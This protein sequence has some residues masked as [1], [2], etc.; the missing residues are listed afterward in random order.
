MNN[1]IVILV[2][3]IYIEVKKKNFQNWKHFYDMD[4]LTLAKGQKIKGKKF[5]YFSTGPIIWHHY[6][7]LKFFITAIGGG[8][9]G[10]ENLAFPF[11]CFASPK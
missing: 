8:G 7:A 10:G 2:F 1:I 3:S 4:I 6:H 5:Y 9:G 11:A